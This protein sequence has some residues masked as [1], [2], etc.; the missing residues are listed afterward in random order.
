MIRL[1]LI[2]ALPGLLAGQTLEDRLRQIETQSG[3]VMG[4][5]ALHLET[6]QFIGWRSKDHFPTMSVAKLP[7][8]LR[9]LAQ[10]QAGLLPFRKMVRVEPEQYSTGFSPLRDKYPSG[11]VATI[12]QLMEASLRDSDNTAHDVLLELSGGPTAAQEQLDRL[13][14]GAI[15][16]NRSEKQ[17]NQDLEALGPVAFDADGRD[18]STPEAMTLLLSAIHGRKLVH[19]ASHER[20]IRWMTETPTGAMRIKALLPPGTVV[21]HKTGTGGDKDGINLCTNDTGVIALPGGKGHLALTVF[22]KLSRKPLAD[23]ERAIADTALLFY[24]QFSRQP[25]QPQT[26]EK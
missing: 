13:F 19:P 14:K 8:V 6:G 22:I 9:A 1:F 10:M 24:Q 5:A 11:V 4:V 23:R 17:M 16:I 12:G 7:V 21:W 3:G 15:R 2:L 25:P 26:I 20:I 18:S